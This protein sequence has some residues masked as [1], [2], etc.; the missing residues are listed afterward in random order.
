MSFY[1]FVNSVADYVY[2]TMLEQEYKEECKKRNMVTYQDNIDILEIAC[3]DVLDKIE[4]EKIQYKA[5]YIAQGRNI[6]EAEELSEQAVK[7]KR[8]AVIQNTNER[9][10]T[11]K[12]LI[13]EEKDKNYRIEE[14]NKQKNYNCKKNCLI[15]LIIVFAIALVGMLWI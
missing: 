7:Q 10:D 8:D 14:E 15:V 1:G 5:A 13:Q 11:Y 6:E 2:L 9:I 4:Q 12:K 3:S